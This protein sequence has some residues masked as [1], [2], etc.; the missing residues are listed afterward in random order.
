V[1]KT[2]NELVKLVD[3]VL[4]HYR[5]D[6]YTHDRNILQSY[7]GP[8]IYGYRKTGTDLLRLLNLDA[9]KWRDPLC[10]PEEAEEIM[11]GDFIWIGY[12]ERNF[13]FLHFDG[14]RLRQV[15][16]QECQ[17]IWTAYCDRIVSEMRLKQNP[18]Y[19]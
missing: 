12:Q 13:L 14:K 7:D 11:R 2:Y 17:D 18:V 19:V 6:L 8:F 3:P 16:L 1:T 15:T 4:K 10:T 9:I 5:E